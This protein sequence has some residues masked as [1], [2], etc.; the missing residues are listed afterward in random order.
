VPNP[1]TATL[2]FGPHH[3][4]L[5]SLAAQSLEALLARLEAGPARRITS[6]EV[7]P[8]LGEE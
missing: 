5:D 6:N 4:R 8:L 2:R 7:Q 3:L 1:V